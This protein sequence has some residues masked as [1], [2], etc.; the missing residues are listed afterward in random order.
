MGQIGEAFIRL[1]AKGG[2]TVRA[3]L[4]K[5]RRSLRGLGRNAD[6]SLGKFG[7]R[8]DA[9]TE[10]ARKLQGAVGG[11]LGIVAVVGGVAFKAGQGIF[12][13]SQALREGTE[14]AREF[15]AA[16]DDSGSLEAAQSN[17]SAIRE[18]TEELNALLANEA[19]GGFV[20]SIEV[21]LRGGTERVRETRDALNAEAL[22]FSRRIAAENEKAERERLAAIR[23]I[24]TTTREATE[25]ELLRTKAANE[26]DAA[27]RAAL[28]VEATNIEYQRELL[29]IAEQLAVAEELEEQ[30]AIDGLR[31]R[32]RLAAEI[33]AEQIRAINAARDAAIEADAKVKR[34]KLENERQV[35]EAIIEGNRAAIAAASQAAA[36]AISNAIGANGPI[37]QIGE[38]VADIADKIELIEGRR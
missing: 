17:L 16:L 23:E 30:S 22:Q 12:A 6:A 18:E 33:N 11:V 19:A 7:D 24:A 5:V 21:A 34:E 9:S 15:V 20:A 38:L 4:V 8:L 35:R 31:A 13:L 25:L 29:D 36:D 26:T 27:K 3:E 37:Q 10:G 28:E 32:R 1:S 2:E 14:N